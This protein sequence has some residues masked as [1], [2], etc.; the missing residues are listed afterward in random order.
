MR[1]YNVPTN[2]ISESVRLPNRKAM[3][4]CRSGAGEAG[5]ENAGEHIET[6]AVIGHIKSDV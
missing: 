6:S 2:R 4:R 3:V 5:E 1:K